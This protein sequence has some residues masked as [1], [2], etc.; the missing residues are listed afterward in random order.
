ANHHEKEPPA[1]ILSRIAWGAERVAGAF[2][3]GDINQGKKDALA[4]MK[5]LG[6]QQGAAMNV[7]DRVPALL[8]EA[9][10]AFDR[11]IPAQEKLD[12]LVLDANRRLVEM[13]NNYERVLVQLEQLIHEKDELTVQLRLANQELA[14]VA[15]TD[16]LTGLPNRR[17]FEEA[18][19][20]DLARAERTKEALAVVMI[21]VDFFKKVNDTYGHATGDV[22]LRSVAEVLRSTLRTGDVPARLGG[23]EFVA[24]LP[25]ANGEGGRIVAE[26]LRMK[27]AATPM[28]GPSGAFNVT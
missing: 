22:V 27:L 4:F 20:R 15:A 28:Q 26:R 1:A 18:M 9:A 8:G 6:L 24:L 14:A 23:E 25:N 16:A 3:A 2:E 12:A 7:L 10:S 21:D 19:R 13:N 5:Q 11:P 17:A